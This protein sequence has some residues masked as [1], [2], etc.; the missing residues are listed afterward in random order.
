MATKKKGGGTSIRGSATIC[1]VL[2]YLGFNIRIID[3][4]N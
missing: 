3:D 1:K 2:R 4:Y